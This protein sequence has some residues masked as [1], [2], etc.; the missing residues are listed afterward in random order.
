MV[1]I[2][3]VDSNP[4]VYNIVLAYHLVINCIYFFSHR[5][6]WHINSMTI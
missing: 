4:I 2:K 1:P 3:K 6:V 5:N